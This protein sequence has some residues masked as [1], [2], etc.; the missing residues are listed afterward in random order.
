[1]KKK[2]D[3]DNMMSEKA[4]LQ[5]RYS[6]RKYTKDPI[7]TDTVKELEKAIMLC[8]EK[9]GL[10][11]RMYLEEPQAFHQIIKRFS[12]FQNVKNYIALIGEPSEHLAED[13]GY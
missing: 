6:I 4:A 9:S 1:M 5:K 3:V 10:H 12:R 7:E 13:C 2:E 11:I 8:N